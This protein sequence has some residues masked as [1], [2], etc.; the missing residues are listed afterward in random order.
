MILYQLFETSI[1]YAGHDPVDAARQA[2]ML[3]ARPS[4]PPRKSIS[5]VTAV[6]EGGGGAGPHRRPRR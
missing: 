6:R 1:P 2:A 5:P 3:G 4:F